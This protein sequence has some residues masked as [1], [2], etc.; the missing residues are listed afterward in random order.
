MHGKATCCLKVRAAKGSI[1]V[2]SGTV[3]ICLSFNKHNS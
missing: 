3:Y 2:I 1:K